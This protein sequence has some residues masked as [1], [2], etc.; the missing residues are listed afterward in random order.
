MVA[1]MIP[2]LPTARVMN[3]LSA[4]RSICA[5]TECHLLLAQRS[6]GCL[7]EHGGVMLATSG[8]YPRGLSQP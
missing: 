2:L 1:D 7:A 6:T 4:T 3:V 8:S 5:R